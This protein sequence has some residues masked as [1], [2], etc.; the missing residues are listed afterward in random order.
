VQRTLTTL[1][2]K[3]YALSI[4][5]NQLSADMRSMFPNETGFSVTNLKYMKRWYLFYND[6]VAIRQQAADEIGHQAGDEIQKQVLTIRHQAGDELGMP[7]IFGRVPWKHHVEIFTKSQSL[8]EVMKVHA[9][10]PHGWQTMMLMLEGMLPY[11]SM[12]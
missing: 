7:T 5:F 2:I 3:N 9:N 11:L 10:V 6:Q 8:E 4:I 1:N 12:D